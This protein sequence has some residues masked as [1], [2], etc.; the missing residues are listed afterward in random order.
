MDLRIAAFHCA[1]VYLRKHTPN[2]SGISFLLRIQ[3]FL[4]KYI[5]GRSK[6]VRDNDKEP[7]LVNILSHSLIALRYT[8]VHSA[9]KIFAYLR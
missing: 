2:L 5:H 1:Y 9:G 7:A 6:L 8:R 4:P 3:L